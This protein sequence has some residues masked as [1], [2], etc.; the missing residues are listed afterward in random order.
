MRGWAPGAAVEFWVMTTDV[1][2]TWAPYA[3]WR[4]ISDGAVGN[5]GMHAATT[6]GQGFD[7][8]QTFA[9]RLK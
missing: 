8:L 4:R 2:Q 5:D 3:G 1:G 9:V 6:D 7:F